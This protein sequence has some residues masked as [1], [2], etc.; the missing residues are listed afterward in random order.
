MGY[1]IA[2]EHLL[3]KVHTDTVWVVDANVRL[4]LTHV[5]SAVLVSIQHSLSVLWC[6]ALVTRG[7][8]GHT[9]G[10]LLGQFVAE[11]LL[12]RLHYVWHHRVD[13]RQRLDGP[14]VKH[15]TILQGENTH[16]VTEPSVFTKTMKSELTPP[17]MGL[18]FLCLSDTIV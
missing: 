10:L 12:P 15:R 1:H 2:V 16:T 13:K 17:T 6:V 14:S 8:G 4:A 5:V 7:A 18:D 11:S 3:I 9:A